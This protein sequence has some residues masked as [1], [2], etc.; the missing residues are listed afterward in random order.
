MSGTRGIVAAAGYVPYRRLQR[1]EI[2]AFFGSGGGR[3]TRSVAS[4]D[5]DTTSMGVEAARLAMRGTEVAP[6]TLLF[7]TADPAYLEKTNATTVHAA[8]RLG[9]DVAAFDA[10]GAVRSG[11]GALTFALRADHPV[12]VVSSDFRGG[13]P[14]SADEAGS[15]D[16]AAALLVGDGPGVVA[17]HIGGASRT[18]EFIDRWRTPG[19]PRPRQWEERFG[20]V[21][22]TALADEAWNEALKR[23]DLEAEKVDVTILTGTH[24]RAVKSIAGKL[25][26]PRIADDRT[27][28]D[29]P[30]RVRARRAPAQRHARAGRA[31]AGDRARAALRRRRRVA[32]P[33]HRRDQELAAGPHRCDAAR[34]HCRPAVR[35]VPV[36]A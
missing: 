11:I 7:A 25:G 16:G 8:L 22:Y 5:E 29:R 18:R 33:R 19:D 6:E 13:L 23:A 28:V 21:Q 27:S 9:A 4:Y 10:G 2:A 12:L 1:A 36:V 17:E 15:G 14:T 26:A 24:P 3:G 32:V 30:D 35:E 31:G 20:E 34:A